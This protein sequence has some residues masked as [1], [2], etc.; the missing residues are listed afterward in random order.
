MVYKQNSGAKMQFIWK[1]GF[2][3]G[4][5][6]GRHVIMIMNARTEQDS[7]VTTKLNVLGIHGM[8]MINYKN[9]ECVPRLKWSQK[10]M[11]G[12]QA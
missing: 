3:M 8:N 4:V 9:C 6:E 11:D 12:A 5:M 1:E 2:L 7:N 10:Q